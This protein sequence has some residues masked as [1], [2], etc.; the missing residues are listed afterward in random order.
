MITRHDMIEI[1]VMLMLMLMICSRICNCIPS[2]VPIIP[3]DAREV[4]GPTWGLMGAKISWGTKIICTY[5][6]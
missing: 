5:L 4:S 6:M 1:D 3:C 2:V